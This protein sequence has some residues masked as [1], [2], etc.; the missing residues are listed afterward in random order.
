M[1]KTIRYEGQTHQFPDDFSDAD[2]QAA[3]SMAQPAKPA[4]AQS[5]IL[6]VAAD[7]ATGVGK[8][9]LSTVVHGGD[10]I[11]RGLGMERIVEKP[12]VKALITP[13]TTAQK[14]GY[15]V[16]QA[17]EFLVPGAAVSR[18]AKGVQAATS[19]MRGGGIVNAYGRAVLEGAAAGAVSGVQ[20]GG[21]T[22]A[23]RDSALTGWA[24]SGAGS[25]IVA[26]A[27]PVANMLKKSA[28]EQYGRAL[29]PTKKSTKFLAKE[30][31]V[32]GLIERGVMSRSID[33][34]AAK[35]SGR[36]A[37]LGKQI[38]DAWDNLPV[39]TKVEADAIFTKL[40]DAITPHTVLNSAGKRI[41]KDD[42]ANTAIS[43][44]ESLQA[45]LLDV[46][47]RNPA[48]GKLEIPV[49]KIRD[50]RQYWDNYAARAGRY[51]GT[52]LAEA[53][54]AEAQGLAADAIR[55]ELGKEFPDIAKIN[56]EFHFWKNAQKVA[57]ETAERRVGQSKGLVRRM[58]GAIGAAAGGAMTQSLEGIV[59][60]KVAI[61]Q[62][63]KLVSSTAWNTVT[64]IIKD[65]LAEAIA[66]GN[67][68]AAEFYI[69]KAFRAAATSAISNRS[70]NASPALSPGQ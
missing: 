17:A 46:A 12:E 36:V 66:A 28:V 5:G 65:R 39:G 54:K 45:T 33:S 4:P 47:E 68:G 23:M 60:G 2:I 38:G 15:G 40:E 64:P 59:I 55:G 34:L 26:G 22:G 30:E 25:A 42:V 10:L 13:T 52:S 41:P 6:D 16:E 27:K 48:T 56:K 20:T 35:A 63:E 51:H 61:D 44:L 3:L 8:G 29:N 62:F 50:L 57:Q 14:V 69:G 67:R 21:D 70:D 24:L 11:R 19:G 7:A 43:N 31:V 9:V 58:S 53:S 1:P 37:E 18:A 49:E 32:P